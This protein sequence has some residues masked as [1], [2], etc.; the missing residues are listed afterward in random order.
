MPTVKLLNSCAFCCVFVCALYSFGCGGNDGPKRYRITGTITFKGEPVP[1]GY[2]QF[3]PEP[4]TRGPEGFA[5]VLDGKFSTDNYGRGVIGGPHKVIIEGSSGGEPN[6]D[7]EIP[8]GEKLFDK[9]E[10]TYTFDEANSEVDFEV[11]TE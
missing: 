5:E 7:G 3:I 9:Y 4:A 11:V 1:V 10:T 6:E 2:I 8:Q